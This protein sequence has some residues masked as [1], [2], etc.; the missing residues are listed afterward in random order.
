M[1]VGKQYVTC[2][3]IIQNLLHNLQKIQCDGPCPCAESGSSS[4]EEVP[5]MM[6]TE[7]TMK[8][9]SSTMDP[10]SEETV[11]PTMMPSSE[12]SVEP[13]MMPSSEESMEP[14][15]MPPSG[16]TIE[17]PDDYSSEEI[18]SKETME[19]SSETVDPVRP[20]P[21]PFLLSPVC[22]TNGQFYPNSCVAK[23]AKTVN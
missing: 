19:T 2:N 18:A 11:E 22:G 14:T 21:C 17:E 9:M 6:P 3:T 5:T 8:P 1:N 23:C 12:E 13:T 4:S 20:C 10:S 15:M 7:S 16:E